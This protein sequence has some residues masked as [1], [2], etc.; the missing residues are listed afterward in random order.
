M[1]QAEGTLTNRPPLYLAFLGTGWIGRHRMQSLIGTGFVEVAAIADPSAEMIE[2]AK[3][4]APKAA[5]CSDLADIMALKPDGL[6]IATPSA[7]HAQ[8]SIEALSH[9][10]PVFCQKPLGRNAAEVAA[11]IAAARSA[12]RLLGV[13]FSYRKTRGMMAIQELV[14]AAALGRI[15]SIDLEFHN[16]YGPD[17]DWFYDR[18]LSGGGCVMDLGVHLVDLAM[19]LTGN[20]SVH[21]VSSSLFADGER[22]TA[23]S[24]T[25]EDYALATIETESG[26]VIRLA[27]SWRAHAGSDAEIK[28]DVR[29]TKG[30]ARFVNLGGSF[31]DFQ[32][33]RYRGTERDILT[34][35]PEDWGGKAII[36]WAKT[37][38]VSARHDPTTDRIL[39]VT[40]VID[41][42]YAGR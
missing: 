8:Q 9:G 35:P 14:D 30:G 37:L 2:E 3:I 16:A 41:R 34:E 40:E 11:V 22:L 6:V 24:S 10:I 20:Q 33:L 1:M 5:V 26:A 36:D 31:F 21:S 15:F 39:A 29:G 32:A 23:G 12:D 38:Q 25:V 18:T 42:I 4:L 13:D 28:V 7:L 17:K 27:C 19:A